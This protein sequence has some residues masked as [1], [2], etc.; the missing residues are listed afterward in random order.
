MA[1][2]NVYIPDDRNVV[3]ITTAS[4]EVVPECVAVRLLFDSVKSLSI[5][6]GFQV[7]AG[8]GGGGGAVTVTVTVAEAVPPCPVAV[9]E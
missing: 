8:G 2:V 9:I 5:A 3:A 4:S 6:A 1:R 7:V